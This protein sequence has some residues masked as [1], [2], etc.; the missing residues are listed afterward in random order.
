MRWL[1][2]A[3]CGF[4]VLCLLLPWAAAQPS[5]AQET[6]GVPLPVAALGD[7][8]RLLI[9]REYIKNT[10]TPRIEDNVPSWVAFSTYV[11]AGKPEEDA[12]W[13]PGTALRSL[14]LAYLVSNDAAYAKR[15]KTI[16]VDLANRIEADPVMTREGGLTGQFMEDV[17]ALAVG[18][19]WLYRSLAEN[20][21][22]ELQQT[23]WRAVK[24]LRDP[25]ADTGGLLWV[26]G[27]MDLFGNY[28]PRWLWALTA[29][30]LALRGEHPEAE[31]LL[32]FCRE[33]LTGSVIPALDL[34]SGGAWSEG[35]V[36]GFIANWA[37]AQTALAWWTAAGENMFDDTLWWYERLA[38]D[39]FMYYP[40]SMRTYNAE[41]G[42]AIPGY[43]AIIGDSE[44]YHAVA[45][46]GRA[47]D[48]LLSAIFTGHDYADWM[49]WYLR[50]P[51][52]GLPGWMAAEEFLWRDPDN[53]G[54][55]PT[56]R[57]WIAPFNGHVFMRSNWINRDGL[58]DPTA[59]H[60]TFNAGDRLSYHQYYDQGSFTF[61]YNGADLVVRS[62]VYSGDGTSDHDA[63]YNARTIAGNTVLIC[64]LGETFDGIRPDGERDVWLNDCGQRSMS[65]GS[66]TAINLD[67]LLENWRIYDTGSVTRVAELGDAT[68]IR[69][70]LTGAYN[71][72]LVTTPE[73]SAKVRSVVRELVFWRP[74]L[75]IVYDR[76]SV[77]YPSYTPMTVFHFQ[78][79]PLPTGI[80]FRS[81]V[82]N[83]AVYMQ[84]LLPNSRVTMVQG[85]QV[86]GQMIDQSWG[87]PASNT[88]EDQPYGIYRMEIAPGGPD[89][90]HWFM[91]AFVAQYADADTPAPGI[92]VQGEEMRGVVMGSNQV[93]FDEEPGD[94]QDVIQARFPIGEGV[95]FTVVTG[96]RPSGSYAVT[97]DGSAVSQALSANEAGMLVITN[98]PPGAVSLT[99]Q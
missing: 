95:A 70:D 12:E 66:R 40:V 78:T 94:G 27:E 52:Y 31:S 81:V 10:L 15:A 3:V 68:Y 63:N 93:M 48:L 59:A 57:T 20:D 99:L 45:V 55:P 18:Y 92:L 42:D 64:D 22:A 77:T 28:Q 39:L 62:G 11:E 29:V 89:L 85:Y 69:A 7:H 96:L 33:Q 79:E 50:Q 47:Q 46:Y 44:R 53:V 26:D 65:P 19:D 61:F 43:P 83:T 14:A 25:M 84:N 9:T 32:D 49:N 6:G 1:R 21:R 76:V 51:P 24:R 35:P 54:L 13:T 74:N 90:E 37:T 58:F 80:Y 8:P 17:A 41:W 73:N 75:V 38:Y 30:G 36:Y 88:F 97:T 67:Y 71:S 5:I 60:V 34:Q 98:A 56:E 86:A 2:P 4:I 91:S 87:E 72:T 16:M 82:D 23:L